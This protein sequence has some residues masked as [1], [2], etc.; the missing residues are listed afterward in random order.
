[1]AKQLRVA[2]LFAGWGGF[3]L[4]AEEA[5]HKVVWAANHW[6]VAVEA[7]SIMH[8]EVQH[9]C[10]DVEQADWT[11]LPAY[12]LLVASPACQ[13]HSSA[14]QPK[15]RAHHD[16]QRATAWAVVQA[17]EITRPKAFIVENVPQFKRWGPKGGKPG[18]LYQHWK[19]A[20][21]I[22]GY[23]VTEHMIDATFHGVPQRRKRLFL[24]GMLKPGFQYKPMRPLDSPEP[25]FGPMIDWGQG[26][27]RPLEKAPPA[28]QA[29]MLA[30]QQRFGVR[31]RYVG[32]DV[33]GHAGIP[34]TEAIRTITCQDQWWVTRGR[35]VYR[36][37]TERETARAMGFPEWYQWPDWATRTDII[38]G[39]GNAVCPPVARDLIQ[40]VAAA[41]GPARRAKPRQLQAAKTRK[42]RSKKA[43]AAPE[44]L[45]LIELAKKAR[46]NPDE[47]AAIKSRLVSY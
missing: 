22:L 15:R 40:Q 21:E 37:L 3:T 23:H 34:L 46:G 24:V 12:D 2:D 42:P 17:V 35:G 44:S 31:A 6:T 16:A 1:M 19:E 43:I 45:S 33:T 25:A 9:V 18:A 27:W 10:Q 4:G 11:L 14:S 32:Q 20:L 41:M 36:P 28:K 7:H 29:R 38:T 47:I 39:L 30:G 13:P 5:G 8:P 26:R